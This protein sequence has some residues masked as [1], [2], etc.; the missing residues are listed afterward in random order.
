MQ[1]IFFWWIAFWLCNSAT[2]LAQDFGIYGL[3][4]RGGV[5]TTFATDYQSI[6]IN[7]ANLGVRESFRDPRFTIGLLEGNLQI[8]SESLTRNDILQSLFNPDQVQFSL[9]EKRQAAQKLTDNAL[10]L[11][12]NVIVFGAAFSDPVFGGLAFSIQDNIQLLARLNQTTSEILFLGDNAPYFPFLILNNGLIIPNNETVTD[13]QREQVIEGTFQ[14]TTQASTYGQILDGSTFSANWYREYAIAYGRKWLNTYGLQIYA[15]ATLKII[16]GI[17][18]IDLAAQNG[19]LTRETISLSP[20]FEVDFDAVDTPTAKGF[21]D[22]STFLNRALFP[23]S[24]GQGFGF[25]AGVHAVIKQ[26]LHIGVALNNVGSVNWNGN[27]YRL[28][29]GILA[30]FQGSGYN[31]YHFPQVSPDAFQF[32]GSASP[33]DWQ[34]SNEVRISLPTQIRAGISYNF[35]KTAHVGVD[36]VLPQNDA[37]GNLLEPFYAIGVDYRLTRTI[38]LSTGFNRGGNKGSVFNLPFA[39]TYQHPR[40]IYEVGIATRDL[41]TYITDI[42][43]GAVLSMAV[44]FFRVKL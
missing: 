35:F 30:S 26:N 4:G 7:P 3:V 22:A 43:E 1:R 23:E 28:N 8:S 34:G 12:A 39:I 24:V 19:V 9:A 15:G 6:N 40:G 11:D 2:L 13:Q 32:A 38:T 33:L 42:G 21:A 17:T 25:N 20:S 16:R 18:I 41:N 14:D 29:D 5:G 10:A 37:P 27:V 44:G 31:N 36:V